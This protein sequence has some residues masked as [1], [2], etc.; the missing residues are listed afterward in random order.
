MKGR[1]KGSDIVE[2]TY[3]VE[4]CRLAGG[5]RREKREGGRGKRIS[6]A[7]ERLA[8]L[9]D[10]PTEGE[11]DKPSPESMLK[12]Q[13][14]RGTKQEIEREKTPRKVRTDGEEARCPRLGG[15]L[16]S[17]VFFPIPILKRGHH[18]AFQ[19]VV[20]GIPFVLV[21]NII[22]DVFIFDAWCGFHL[23]IARRG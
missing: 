16:L 5:V 18:F 2:W 13:V 12:I 17:A 14:I 6:Q 15:L 3:R 23:I 4:E 7:A 8:M 21:L 20:I 9:T 22:L 1:A 19:F 11:P 10:R